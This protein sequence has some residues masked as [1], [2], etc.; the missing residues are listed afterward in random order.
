MGLLNCLRAMEVV[1]MKS[2]SVTY[3]TS[4]AFQIL[5]FIFIFFGGVILF[6]LL[7]PGC[8]MSSMIG[9]CMVCLFTG[10]IFMMLGF[11]MITFQKTVTVNNEAEKLEVVESSI[12]GYRR[13]CIHFSEISEIEIS[14][15]CQTILGNASEL[16][17]I[18]VYVS[19]LDNQGIKHFSKVVKIFETDIEDEARKAA[20][21]FTRLKNIDIIYGYVGNKRLRASY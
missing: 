3:R 6:G 18:R 13:S 9:M 12:F 20:E 2:N 17:V 21:C 19:K 11:A 15:E 8:R 7:F 5:G 10:V 16:F 1:G 4:W 14:K